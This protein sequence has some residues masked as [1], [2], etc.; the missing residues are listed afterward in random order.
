M[1]GILVGRKLT[2]NPGIVADSVGLITKVQFWNVGPGLFTTGK[3][4]AEFEADIPDGVFD[5]DRSGVMCTSDDC[6]SGCCVGRL[7]CS[8]LSSSCFVASTSNG[9]ATIC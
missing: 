2:G 7:I 8:E 9:S 1:F 6:E 3:F 4:D 5:D